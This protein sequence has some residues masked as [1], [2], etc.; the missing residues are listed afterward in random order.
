MTPETNHKWIKRPTKKKKR[1]RRKGE[2]KQSRKEGKQ[3]RSQIIK[4]EQHS[5]PRACQLVDETSRPPGCSLE[6]W[7]GLHCIFVC[8]VLMFR[9][10]LG[11]WAG[12]GRHEVPICQE[13]FRMDEKKQKETSISQII[14]TYRREFVRITSLLLIY[15]LPSDFC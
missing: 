6:V 2:E 4:G 7:K 15:S 8:D 14:P 1:R 9:R 3:G 11:G 10:G 13:G 12:A 5:Q